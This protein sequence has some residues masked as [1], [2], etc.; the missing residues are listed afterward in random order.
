MIGQGVN[1]DEKGELADEESEENLDEALEEEPDDE[2]V[3]F[4]DDLLSLCVLQYTSGTEKTSKMLT[5]TSTGS[6]TRMSRGPFSRIPAQQVPDYEFQL[7][8]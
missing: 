3:R 1:C 8:S 4:D 5:G 6:P 2:N 7:A